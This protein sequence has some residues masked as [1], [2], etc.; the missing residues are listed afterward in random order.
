MKLGSHGL[1][2]IKSFEGFVPYVYDDLVP[3]VRGKYREWDGGAV[4]GTL[5]IGYGHTDAARHPIKCHL[6]TQVTEA[7]ATQILDV[8]LG[9]CVDEVNRAV[10]VRVSQGQFDAL[11]SFAYNCGVGN[12]KK[13]TAVLNR[14]D[15]AGARAKL[16]EFIRSK[17]Q[18]LNGLVRRRTA[19]QALWDD[20]YVEADKAEP[21]ADKPVLTPKDVTP[22]EPPKP[23]AQSKTFWATIVTALATVWSAVQTALETALTDWRVWFAIVALLA[24]GYIIWERNGKP[25]I[26]GLISSGD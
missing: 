25:D 10:K 14:G 24:L 16:G 26:R 21:P 7:E 9:E 12:L 19:E 15:Y 23:L 4:R 5:T 22:E 3:P 13:V 6:G 17:G 11:V 8:D 18:V 2:L 20:D 1:K